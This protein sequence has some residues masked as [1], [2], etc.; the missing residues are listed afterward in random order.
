VIRHAITMQIAY[1]G[2]N[3]LDIESGCEYKN[4]TEIWLNAWLTGAVC[5]AS[6]KVVGTV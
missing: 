1:P 3:F 4:N 5:L 6:Y 2:L